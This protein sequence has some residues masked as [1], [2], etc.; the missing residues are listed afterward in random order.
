METGKRDGEI[1]N[2]MKNAW[3]SLGPGAALIILLTVVVYLPAMRGGFLWDDVYL[4]LENPLVKMSDGLYRFW[5]T[6]EPID[7]WPLTLTTWWVEW[8]LWDGNPLG[9]HV[10]NVILH[11]LSAVLWW[12]LLAR[13]KIPGAWLAAAVFAVHPV[14]VESVAWISERK[15]TLAMLFYTLTLLCYL[16]FEDIGQRRWYWLA[17]GTFVLAMLSK[18]AVVML[19]WVL[20]GFGW[21]RRG[22]LGRKDVLRS[23]PFFAAAVLLGLVTVW[24]QY[25][26]SIGS[27]V[28]R[29]DSFWLRLA[30]AGWAVWFYIC[31]ALFPLNLCFVYPR[32]Q[33]DAKNFLSYVPGLLLV[34]GLLLSWRYRRGWG[35]PL[36]CGLGYFVVMLFPA[37]GFVNIYF[38]R[39]SLVADHWQYFSLIGLVALAVSWGVAI[40]RRSG[41]RGRYVSLLSGTVVLVALGLCTWK[42]ACIYRDAETLWRD[43]LAKNP[44]SWLAHNNLGGVLIRQ[45]KVP[46]AVIHLEQAVRLKPDYAEAHFN[47]AAALE[48]VGK[49][50]DAIGQYEQALRFNPDYTEAHYNLG[51]ALQQVGKLEE[52]IRHYE[53]A[54]HVNPDYA[55]AHN[56]LAVALEQVGKFEDAIRH[57]KQAVQIKPDYAD[58]HYNLGVALEQVGRVQEAIG[59]Y[60]QAL[61]I[62]PGAVEAQN[63]LARLRAAP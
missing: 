57:W 49:L 56:N 55:E 21:W 7:Y 59:H 2:T 32:W 45:G 11:A 42:Q 4:V 53:Q 10:I 34:V 27:D 43:T 52:A 58:A 26:R 61:R 47:L 28:V 23:I 8:R 3:R 35:R 14:N 37:L 62:N 63:K 36:L 33:I 30:G 17:A 40:C 41:E 54:L 44:G 18:A 29:A 19:P 25:H 20:L 16:R 46:E 50:E 48:R 24:F 13:L 12:R 1:R 6:T 5:C 9:Y 31:R 15:N 22:R 39:Y 60:E 51:V 38:M